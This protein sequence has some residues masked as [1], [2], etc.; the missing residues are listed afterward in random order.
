MTGQIFGPA[1][2]LPTSILRFCYAIVALLC[3]SNT[4]L[5]QTATAI[6]LDSTGVRLQFASS[7]A[8]KSLQF[9]AINVGEI[10]TVAIGADG[11]LQL[12]LRR[13]RP[14][15]NAPACIFAYNPRSGE[16]AKLT[17]LS[18]FR[19]PFWEASALGDS[20]APVRTVAQIDDELARLESSAADAR[21]RIANQRGALGGERCS[22]MVEAHRSRSPYAL[23]GD[24]ARIYGAA[25]CSALFGPGPIG[26]ADVARGSAMGDDPLFAQPGCNTRLRAAMQVAGGGRDPVNGTRH[27]AIAQSAVRAAAARPGEHDEI[28]RACIVDVARDSTEM[29]LAWR[30]TVAAQE[31]T[32]GSDRDRCVG[33]AATLAEAGPRRAEL[34]RERAVARRF[35]SLLAGVS[36]D[37]MMNQCTP[38]ARQ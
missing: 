14:L 15:R 26:C 4:A 32:V 29:L 17:R 11:M 10:G 9:F 38:V 18:G 31:K 30:N 6:S 22:T 33:A 24:A 13:V 20:G 34:M 25:R 8:F 28:A 2:R 27:S 12:D 36:R 35:E 3:L 21:D 19:N 23:D 16:L 1:R 5:A 7:N 37:G